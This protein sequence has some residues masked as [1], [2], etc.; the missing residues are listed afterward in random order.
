M[1][2]REFMGAVAAAAAAVAASSA[3]AEDMP[4]GH[5]HHHAAKYAAVAA[6]AAKC[7]TTGNDC[8]RHCYEMLSMK[9]TSMADCTRSTADLIAAC[10]ALAS[11]AALNSPFTPAI[12]KTVAEVCLACKKECD[13]FPQQAECKACGEACAACAEEC[14]KVAA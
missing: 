1:E 3:R 13:K 2:R 5:A 7:V 12:A 4:A 8:L 6:S 9:D 11:L 14:K 10:G